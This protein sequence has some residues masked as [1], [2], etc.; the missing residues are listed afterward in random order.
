M[1]NGHFVRNKCSVDFSLPCFGN[2]R[3]FGYT[4]FLGFYNIT[5]F[6]VKHPWKFLFPIMRMH[7]KYFILRVLNKTKK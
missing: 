2:A 7:P 3:K 4:R 1:I 5:L 6:I